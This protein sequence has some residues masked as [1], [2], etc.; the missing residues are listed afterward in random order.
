[1]SEDTK[2]T[3]LCTIGQDRKTFLGHVG[4][5]LLGGNIGTQFDRIIKW[6]VNKGNHIAELVGNEVAIVVTWNERTVVEFQIH[7][8]NCR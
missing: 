2:E 7:I 8:D 4:I 3:K 6:L 5:R 1:M